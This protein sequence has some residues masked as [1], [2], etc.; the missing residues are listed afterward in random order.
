MNQSESNPLRQELARSAQA[1]RHP[2]A[3]LLTAFTEGA[4]LER[5][6]QDVFAHLA[7]CADCRELL[8]MAS[9]TAANPVATT[10]PF[11]LPR[12]KYPQLRTGLAWASVAAGIL[13]VCSAGLIYKQQLE[14]KQRAT[15][16]AENAPP[17]PSATIQEPKS[18]PAA[19]SKSLISP[20][21]TRAP[22]RLK[23][24][25]P[26]KEATVEATAGQSAPAA[27]KESEASLQNSP[28]QTVAVAPVIA[29]SS[30]VQPPAPEQMSPAFANTM[31]ARALS[32]AS[33]TGVSTR[34][35]WRIDSMG[36]AERSFGNGAW[37]PV[38][39][40]EDAKML[41]V[42]VFDSQVWVGGENTRLYHSADNGNNW[43]LVPLPLKNGLDHGI[44]HIRF[45]TQATGVVE[46]SDGTSWI[47]TDGGVS[48]Q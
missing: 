40:N 48:W 30:I 31:T 46:A 9:G 21:A 45:Q 2:D 43:T 29:E 15:I 18:S 25:V 20:A 8:S 37:Q 47:T 41:V 16:L 35:H 19:K 28:V 23:A 33:M 3:N 17:P 22:A 27:Q 6:R 1:G 36:K 44:V 11:L 10:K 26:S 32:H 39:P 38:L 5:E 12:P 13:A 4:L 7:T 14:L 24:P 42:S 34:P